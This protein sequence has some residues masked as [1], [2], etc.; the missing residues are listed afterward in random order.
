MPRNNFA[1]RF[2]CSSCGWSMSC[3]SCGSA[4]RWSTPR[5]GTAICAFCKHEQELPHSCQRCHQPGLTSL[6]LHHDTFRTTIDMLFPDRKEHMHVLAYFD[7]L[8]DEAQLV[9]HVSG[10]ALLQFPDISAED[11]T[12][13]MIQ[14]IAGRY[15]N[16]HT[17]VQTYEP[18]FRLWSLWATHQD[19]VWY[20]TLWQER[21]D[22][23]V[24][25]A[26]AGMM[27][28]YRGADAERTVQEKKKELEHD[29][30]KKLSILLLP[31]QQRTAAH[32]AI[33]RLLITCTDGIHPA[34]RIPWQ[35]TFP[36]PW[37]VDMA[38]D[39]WLV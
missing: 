27:V 39:S 22:L 20:Q 35:T 5:G 3:S 6:G 10:D 33:Y 12:Y 25:P 4:I 37:A 17:V 14:S 21:L 19:H 29:P 9:I 24:P 31:V 11:R 8:P 7:P 32:T 26:C 15:P 28:R 2:G 30:A 36:H 38:P 18:Q 16:A 1:V 13:Q 23:R 34:T